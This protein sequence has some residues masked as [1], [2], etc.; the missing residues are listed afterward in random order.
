[1]GSLPVFAQE[2]SY[3]FKFAPDLWYNDVDGIRV[4]V[5]VFGEEAFQEGRYRIDAGV[6]LSTW[7]PDLPI[8]YYFSIT[9]PLPGIS[10]YANEG[11]VQLISSIRTGFS[12]HR[13]QFNKR[14]QPGFDEYDYKEFS[15]YLSIE[16][17]FDPEYR[18]FPGLWQQDFKGIVGLNYRYSSNLEIGRFTAIA[19]FMTIETT[20]G[21]GTLELI[22][23]FDLNDNFKLRIRGFAGIASKE[24]DNQYQFLAGMNSAYSTLKKGLTRAKGTIPQTWI[25]N[26]LIQR[27]GGPN[28]RGYLASDI[29]N[30]TNDLNPLYKSFYS[31]NTEF[32]FPNPLNSAIKRIKYIGSLAELR[33]YLFIDAGKGLGF[34]A[35]ERSHN[36]IPDPGF[37]SDAG[38]GLQ[39]SFNIP[40]Y[41]GKDR[42]I[43]IRYDVPFWLS[44]PEED[45]PSFKYRNLIGVGAIFSF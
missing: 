43:F 12:M 29:S 11:S 3:E 10:S 16:N 7:F 14:W 38:L 26:G 45:D 27:E 25:E 42:G 17:M 20:S 44:N 35:D 32:E 41:L 36:A 1:M 13:V 31:L 39:I 9:D 28:L 4:G 21:V 19:D 33:S 22:Q 40:D 15:F 34:D 2:D 24:I 18:A 30:L 6:W 8:S 37:I 5:R 23:R